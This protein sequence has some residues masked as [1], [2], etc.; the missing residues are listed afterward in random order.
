MGNRNQLRQMGTRRKPEVRGDVL[1]NGGPFHGARLRLSY[2]DLSTAV[3]RVGN[4]VGHYNRGAWVPFTTG[5]KV[6]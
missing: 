5:A 6:A 4:S 3:F 1:C 2:P